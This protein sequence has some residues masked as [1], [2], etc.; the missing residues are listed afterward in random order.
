MVPA[1]HDKTSAL[2]NSG[3]AADRE[4]QEWEAHRGEGNSLRLL[5]LG[6]HQQI[7]EVVV[8]RFRL[9]PA[10]GA[11]AATLF[12]LLALV[13]LFLLLLP[14][15]AAALALLSSGSS[16]SRTTTL[17]CSA[18]KPA[19]SIRRATSQYSNTFEYSAR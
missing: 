11:A 10:T 3:T 19:L 4:E 14:A 17:C 7:V 16:R 15:A 12:A 2:N 8:L 6:R 13:L 1:Q 5:R 9:L 18:P